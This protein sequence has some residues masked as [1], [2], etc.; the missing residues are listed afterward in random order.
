MQWISVK[1]QEP[2]LEKY[3]L[4]C[5]YADE[6]D[7]ELFIMVGK[8]PKE[9]PDSGYSLYFPTE[10]GFCAEEL[11]ILLYWMPLPSL[12]KDYQLCDK[13]SGMCITLEDK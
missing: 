12:P 5:G 4:G 3:I 2:P 13:E 9:N 11:V 10:G 1:E 8:V 6:R 7:E